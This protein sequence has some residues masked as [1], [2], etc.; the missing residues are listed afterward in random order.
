L[1]RFLSRR[2][3]R[4][5]MLTSNLRMDSPHF[6]Y[7]LRVTLAASAGITLSTVAGEWLTRYVLPGWVIHDYWVLL[8]ILVSMKAGFA[9]TRQRDSWRLTSRL[10]GC[11]L[12]LVIVNRI[13]SGCTVVSMR[14]MAGVLWYALQDV[15]FM[16][17]ASTNAIFV[18]LAFHFMGPRQP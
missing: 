2:K 9:R 15:H 18:F 14:L 10:I 6:R 7:A 4:L 13:Q 1:D 12:A 11:A 5:G 17:A 16:L 8:S 3:W